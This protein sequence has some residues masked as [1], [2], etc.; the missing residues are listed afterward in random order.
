[1]FKLRWDKYIFK[2]SVQHENMEKVYKYILQ[3]LRH[4]KNRLCLSKNN[5]LLCR[6]PKPQK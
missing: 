5:D 1:M 2:N 3:M 6:D 4:L